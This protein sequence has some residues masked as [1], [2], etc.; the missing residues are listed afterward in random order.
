MENAFLGHQIVQ[1]AFM[2]T[3]NI[4]CVVK[5]GLD[6][7]FHLCP[8]EHP[9]ASS[10]FLNTFHCQKEGKFLRKKVDSWKGKESYKMKL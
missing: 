9:I 6:A 3:L 7:M 5:E 2:Y 10:R 1:L 8:Y 4:N